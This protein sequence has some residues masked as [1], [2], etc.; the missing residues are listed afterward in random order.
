V[1]AE[2]VETEW[3]ARFLAAVGCEFA[4]GFWYS[5]ALP[6]RECTDFVRNFNATAASRAVAGLAS[7][8]GD[9][10]QALK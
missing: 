3:D 7:P 8:F 10:L 2:G 4:Q 6:A 1:V 9:A 5:R